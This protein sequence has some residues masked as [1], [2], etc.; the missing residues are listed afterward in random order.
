YER[1]RQQ[2]LPHEDAV[3]LTLARILITPSFL[4]RAE[5]P[6]PGAKQGPV[7]DWELATRLSYFLWSS[8]P[9]EQL[10]AAAATGALREPE[11]RNSEARR[12]LADPRARRLAVE[13]ACQ[14]LHIRDFDKLDEK[15]ERHFPE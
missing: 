14:W 5:T 15:S 2:E 3:R 6:V 10:L 7:T 9:D 8:M 12:L 4:Y 1:L 11:K 13:F